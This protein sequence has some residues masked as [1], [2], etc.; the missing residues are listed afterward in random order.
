MS[1]HFMPLFW[2]D[3]LR[4]TTGLTAEEHGA[5]LLLIGA[6]WNADGTL[7]ADHKILAR[8]AHVTPRRW[9]KVWETICVFFEIRS[10]A[11]GTSLERKRVTAELQKATAHHARRSNAGKRG[12]AGKWKENKGGSMAMPK[13]SYG[14]PQPEPIK[15]NTAL[16]ERTARAGFKVITGSDDRRALEAYATMEAGN[17][18]GSGSDNEDR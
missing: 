16:S 15:T 4:D 5:Y 2:G 9:P 7:P 18:T 12:A 14:K 8:H 17:A 13:Q 1:N 11:I 6:L 10:N 3:Y